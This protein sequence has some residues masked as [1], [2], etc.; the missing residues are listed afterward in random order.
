MS[1]GEQ[2]A[3]PSQF[4][5]V[6]AIT[7]QLEAG[8]QALFES[9]MFKQYLKT[10]SKFH[11]YSLNNTILIAMQKPDATLVAGYTAW[12]KLF[13]RQV[14]KGESGIRILAPA[15]YKKKME[16]DKTDPVTG[17]VITRPDGTAMKE[18]KEILVPA[19]KVVNV[20]DVSQTEGRPLPSLGVNELTG[21]VAQYDLFSRR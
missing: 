21:D 20:F 5:K 14:Q 13:G 1:A 12:K 9:D 2:K 17:E 7:D 3:Y 6:Q 16:I 19:F 4:E 11:D 15:P 8:I 18:T 10:L